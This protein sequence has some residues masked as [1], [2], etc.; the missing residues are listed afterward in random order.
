M[1]PD[2]ASLSLEFD[3]GW[4][5]EVV[6]E[7]WEDGLHRADHKESAAAL[8]ADAVGCRQGDGHNPMLEE[9]GSVELEKEPEHPIEDLE[10]R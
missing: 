2:N 5:D 9:V 4:P 6:V 3:L 7:E 8:A 1:A 10:G